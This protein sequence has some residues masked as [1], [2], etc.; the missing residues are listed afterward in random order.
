MASQVRCGPRCVPM[1]DQWV[2]KQ[3]GDLRRQLARDLDI[4]DG[5]PAT[6]SRDAGSNTVPVPDTYRLQHG[7]LL[8]FV[9]PP[10]TK[11]SRILILVGEL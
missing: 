1:G 6:V 10:G 11:G 9:R 2:G 4:P 8:E 3:V 7:D 5:A